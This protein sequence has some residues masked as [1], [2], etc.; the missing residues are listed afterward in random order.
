MKE[1][2]NLIGQ[3]CFGF[4]KF[5]SQRNSTEIKWNLRH[6]A[7]HLNG[8]FFVRLLSNAKCA[9]CYTSNESTNMNLHSPRPAL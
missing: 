4:E 7:S 9:E 2:A 3:N 5:T 1:G 8:M 6:A